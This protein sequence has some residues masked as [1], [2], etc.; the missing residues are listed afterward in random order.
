M[1]GTESKQAG[2]EMETKNSCAVLHP[3]L[4]PLVERCL[5]NDSLNSQGGMLEIKKPKSR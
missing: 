2:L 4:L 3:A 5:L 1:K